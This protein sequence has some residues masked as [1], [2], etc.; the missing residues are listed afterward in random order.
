MLKISCYIQ[1]ISLRLEWKT[2]LYCTEETPWPSSLERQEATG[3]KQPTWSSWC[4]P[5]SITWNWN[6][7]MERE[8]QNT[9]SWHKSSHI[10]T[11]LF[12][13]SSALSV[14]IVLCPLHSLF[15][16]MAAKRTVG[17]L[18]YLENLYWGKTT[19]WASMRQEDSM[20]IEFCQNHNL[21]GNREK[22]RLDQSC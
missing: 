6:T 22:M 16:C 10:P 19:A 1:N 18:G 8:H 4:G 11:W 7:N 20:S 12:L 17:D 5:S 14:H 13:L 21:A 2:P 9:E 15:L 3:T